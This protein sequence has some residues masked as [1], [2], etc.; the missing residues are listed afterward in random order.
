MDPDPGLENILYLNKRGGSACS[1]GK[2]DLLV[3]VPKWCL[4]CGGRI[5]LLGTQLLD[6]VLEQSAQISYRIA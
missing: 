4:A 1:N 2:A 5:Q 6:L 3:L